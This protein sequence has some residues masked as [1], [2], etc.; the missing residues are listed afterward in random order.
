MGSVRTSAPHTK[1]RT[2][3]VSEPG[4]NLVPA[5]WDRTYDLTLTGGLLCLLSYAGISLACGRRGLGHLS[6]DDLK[7]RT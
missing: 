2:S 5:A 1:P 7:L 4:L 3:L 6:L